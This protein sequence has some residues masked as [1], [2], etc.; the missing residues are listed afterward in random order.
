MNRQ[1]QRD[2]PA[3]IASLI[4]GKWKRIGVFRISPSG[5]QKHLASTYG[6]SVAC[7]G[8]PDGTHA[9]YVGTGHPRDLPLDVECMY[10]PRDY[11]T[12]RPYDWTRVGT[13]QVCYSTRDGELVELDRR[14]A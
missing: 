5:L 9:M 1:V 3:I 4:P 2:W 11:T 6:I 12:A 10:D 8:R 7:R 14:P 13:E